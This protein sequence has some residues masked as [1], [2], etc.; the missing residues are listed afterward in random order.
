MTSSTLPPT[1]LIGQIVFL[2]DII[3]DPVTGLGIDDSTDAVTIYL[4]DQTNTGSI[5][6]THD[7][8]AGSGRYV[9][10]FTT[11]QAGWHE[12][13]WRS[14]GPGAGASRNWFFVSP[15]P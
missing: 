9:A 15:V 14:T 4:P 7:G 3:T 1:F 11:T 10:Q 6:G 2:Q 5:N 8:M 13:V 12:A